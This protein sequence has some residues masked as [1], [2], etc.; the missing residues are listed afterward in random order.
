MSLCLCQRLINGAVSSKEIQ[1]F[2]CLCYPHQWAGLGNLFPSPSLLFCAS[3]D[4]LLQAAAAGCLCPLASDYIRQWE[5]PAAD[6]RMRE[7]RSRGIYSPPLVQPDYSAPIKHTLSCGDS[8]HWIPVTAPSPCPLR[9]RGWIV[10]LM[11]F[12]SSPCFSV[13]STLLTSLEIICSLYSL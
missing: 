10:P 9:H 5:A 6:Q 12:D 3:K 7:E 4:W 13:P 8:S 11:S 1:F 2:F